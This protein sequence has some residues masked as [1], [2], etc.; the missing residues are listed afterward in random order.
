MLARKQ[1]ELDAK[2]AVDRERP[3]PLVV[4]EERIWTSDANK[5]AYRYY[6]FN[7]GY[8]KPFVTVNLNLLKRN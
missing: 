2:W 8:F 4:K 3:R 1:R 7:M 6:S 5:N